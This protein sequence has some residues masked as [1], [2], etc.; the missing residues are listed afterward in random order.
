MNTATLSPDGKLLATAHDNGTI[1]LWNLEIRQE[2]AVLKAHGGPINSLAFSPDGNTLA[3]GITANR[4][5]R[6]WRAA[7]FEDIPAGGASVPQ[8]R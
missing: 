1:H 3:S 8:P 5:V 7:R 2:V 6:L 4:M